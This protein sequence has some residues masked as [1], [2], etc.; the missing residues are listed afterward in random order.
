MKLPNLIPLP[1]NVLMAE[2]RGT[3]VRSEIPAHTQQRYYILVITTR[4]A[5]LLARP[6]KRGGGC[7][8]NRPVL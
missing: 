4:I 1:D 6:A 5:A 7:Y 8:F 3:A 2:E